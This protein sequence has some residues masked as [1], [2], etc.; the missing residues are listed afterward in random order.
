MAQ[1]RRRT[2]SAPIVRTVR[3]PAP[4]I[5]VSAPRAAPVRR[6]RRR[7]SHSNGSGAVTPGRMF[8]MALGGAIVG[9]VE[10]IPNLPTLPIIGRMG[11]IAVASYFIAKNKGGGVVRDVALASSVLAGY[12][13]GTTGRILGDVVPQVS[14]EGV[15]AQV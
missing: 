1:R 9:F 6:T 8:G 10:K 3:A 2:S 14:G 4:V 11:T 12:Q 7:S 13:L 15:A 5:R